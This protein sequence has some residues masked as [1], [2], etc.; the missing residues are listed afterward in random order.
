MSTDDSLPSLNNPIQA[1]MALVDSS[2]TYTAE[3]M[4]PSEIPGELLCVF[5]LLVQLTTERKHTNT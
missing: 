5:L 4:L 1:K 3:R 2:T